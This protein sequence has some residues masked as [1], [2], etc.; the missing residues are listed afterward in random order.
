MLEKK[1]G[2]LKIAIT[3]QISFYN[4]TIITVKKICK[5]SST[6]V[7]HGSSTTT[8]NRS[9]KVQCQSS[10]K[11]SHLAESRD[12]LRLGPSRPL[13][14]VIRCSANYIPLSPISFLERAAEVYRERTSVIYGSIKYTWEETYHRCIKLAY[15]LS[16]LGIS[17][18][19]VVSI[20]SRFVYAISNNTY[21]SIQENH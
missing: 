21:M 14:G 16:H 4:N 5:K 7:H 17:R 13:E 20:F 15:A 18:G 1:L 11:V 3:K 2:I 8:T 6:R 12:E 19:D 10:P 9:Y